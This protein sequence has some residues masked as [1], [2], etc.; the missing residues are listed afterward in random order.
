MKTRTVT[1]TLLGLALVLA[2][3]AAGAQTRK[4]DESR[5]VDPAASVSISNLAGTLEITGWDRDEVR[6]EGVL[7]AK[8]EKVE[9]EG[10]RK[11]LSIEV[12]YKRNL[13]GSADAT[14]LTLRVPR[15]CALDAESVSCDVTAGDLLGSVSVSTVSGELILRGEPASASMASVSGDVD[16]EVATSRLGI[17]TVSGGIRIRGKLEDL[18]IATVSGDVRVET[19]AL[20]DFEFNAVSG[21][22]ILTADPTDGASWMID[23]HSGAVVLRLPAK[24]DATFDISTFSGDIEDGY[25]HKAERTSK[26][27]PGRELRFTEGKGGAHIDI[28]GFSSDVKLVK[29]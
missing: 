22:L 12:K 16:A 28:S 18:E 19:G 20:R 8:V 27:A 7:D 11:A 6:L 26:H 17:D 23:A 4:V 15:R 2:A 21:Q 25:G 3:T 13:K 5:P 9:I 29:R 1:A 14:R 10:D 24:V